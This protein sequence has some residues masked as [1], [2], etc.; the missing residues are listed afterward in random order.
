MATHARLLSQDLWE[1][2][3]ARAMERGRLPGSEGPAPPGGL[4]GFSRPPLPGSA[5]VRLVL[6]RDAPS[7]HLTPLPLGP[8][9]AL[10]HGHQGEAR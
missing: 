1:S 9:R 2:S 4:P 8:T 7:S 6:P 10:L 5:S 3:T